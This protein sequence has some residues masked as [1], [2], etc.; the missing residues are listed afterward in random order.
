MHAIIV[1]FETIKV[2]FDGMGAGHGTQGYN[3][4]NYVLVCVVSIKLQEDSIPPNYFI[5]SNCRC[6]QAPITSH[7]CTEYF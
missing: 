2:L 5:A 3:R 6:L 7:A 1:L 4:I